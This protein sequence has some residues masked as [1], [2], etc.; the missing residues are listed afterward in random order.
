MTMSV[1][2]QLEREVRTLA[3]DQG[4]PDDA[5]DILA[6]IGRQAIQLG[7]K[8]IDASELHRQLMRLGK[9][10]EDHDKRTS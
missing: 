10:L 3:K 5:V 4:W 6:W 7:G 2:E 8:P 1:R 9:S